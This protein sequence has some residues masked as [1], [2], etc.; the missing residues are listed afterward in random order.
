[1][2]ERSLTR[3]RF[4]RREHANVLDAAAS[5]A[6]DATA[7]VM[8]IIANLIAFT[9]FIGFLDLLVAWFAAQVGYGHVNFTVSTTSHGLVRVY[10]SN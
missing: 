4:F 9:S 3:V 8:S 1:M 6:S 5:G 10:I 2:G 7:L